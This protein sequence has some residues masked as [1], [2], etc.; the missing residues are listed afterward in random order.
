MKTRDK[1]QREKEAVFHTRLYHSNGCLCGRGKQPKFWF[2]YRCYQQLPRDMQ[3]GLWPG[4][5]GDGPE[6]FEEAVAWLK[7]N[8]WY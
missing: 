3:R 7:N 6:N 2:C 1:T 5:D 8:Q 4:L